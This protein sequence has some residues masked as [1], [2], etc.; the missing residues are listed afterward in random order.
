MNP[1][2]ATNEVYVPAFVVEIVDKK[3]DSGCWVFMK[4]QAKAPQ[5]RALPLWIVRYWRPTETGSKQ[6][7]H[8]DEGYRVIGTNYLRIGRRIKKQEAGNAHPPLRP[9]TKP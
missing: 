1:L 3:G 8:W 2:A 5:D 6:I 9:K 7:R 4:G